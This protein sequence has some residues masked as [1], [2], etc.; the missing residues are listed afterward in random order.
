MASLKELLG[1]DYKEDMTIADI[2]GILSGKKVVDLAT[3]DYVSKGKLTDAEKK[4]KDLEKKLTDKLTD[5]EKAE[6]ER[7]KTL[8]YYK[9]IEK[10]YN[11]SKTKEKLSKSIKDDNVLNEVAELYANGDISKA[12]DKQNDYFAKVE[13][14]RQQKQKADDLR[15]N[16]NPAPQND[17][18]KGK[19]DPFAQGFDED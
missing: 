11:I 2:D 15:N 3:G 19:D 10:K 7:Q 13:N 16:P 17:E 12:I 9:D 18:N 5:D 8:E 6:A 1:D 14:D 4:A